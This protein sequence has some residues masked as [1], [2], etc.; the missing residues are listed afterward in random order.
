MW[1]SFCSSPRRK[2]DTRV[3]I[4]AAVV[5]SLVDIPKVGIGKE[6]DKQMDKAENWNKIRLGI[7]LLIMFAAFAGWLNLPKWITDFVISKIVFGLIVGVITGAI[8]GT[9]AE[10]LDKLTNG[11]LKEEWTCEV[12]GIEFS[13]PILVIVTAIIELILFS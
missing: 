9:Y 1:V 8:A 2:V 12:F 5:K 10:F 3:Q 11:I 13:I 4:P 7:W 6:M